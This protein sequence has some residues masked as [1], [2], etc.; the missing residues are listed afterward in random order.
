MATFRVTFSRQGVAPSSYEVEA[1][2]AEDAVDIAEAKHCGNKRWS[3]SVEYELLSGA[4]QPRVYV[5]LPPDGNGMGLGIAVLVLCLGVV[6][7][8]LLL[9]W[10]IL[11]S[12][13]PTF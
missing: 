10:G 12:V 2:N 5:E 6:L 3:G 8:F 11:S 7:A 13:F 9:L 1:P 4:V